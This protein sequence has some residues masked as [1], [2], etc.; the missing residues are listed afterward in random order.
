M[1]D[2]IVQNGKLVD[3]SGGAPHAADVAV[4]DGVISGVGSDLTLGAADSG[5][6]LSA[7]SDSGLSLEADS[8]IKCNVPARRSCLQ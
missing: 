5:I 6:N 1:H 8:G 2:L 3:G 7:P 4:T